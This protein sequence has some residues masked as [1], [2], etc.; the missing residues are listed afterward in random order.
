MNRMLKVNAAN[1]PVTS[2]GPIDTPVVML[3]GGMG[4]RLQSVLPTTPKTLAPVGKLPFLQ[5]LILQLRTQGI[6]RLV[7]CTGHL[8]EQIE[9]EFGDGRKWG[10]TI[11]YSKE[12]CPLGTAG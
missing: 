3:V 5:L 11:D 4:T 8:A 10:V 6:R 1:H 7:M 2:D 12:P 9:A